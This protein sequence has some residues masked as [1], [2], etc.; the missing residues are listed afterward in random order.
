MFEKVDSH[1]H[2][3]I[4]NIETMRSMILMYLA[5]VVKHSVLV[6]NRALRHSLSIHYFIFI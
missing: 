2:R 5:Y 6:E 3:P 1:R 4:H